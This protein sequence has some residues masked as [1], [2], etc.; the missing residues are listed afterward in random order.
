MAAIKAKESSVK[1][2]STIEVVS[3][4]ASAICTKLTVAVPRTN[5]VFFVEKSRP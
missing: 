5:D 1:T 4:M 3:S 2:S